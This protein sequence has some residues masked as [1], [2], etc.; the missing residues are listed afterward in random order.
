MMVVC[1]GAK[2]LLPAIL[3]FPAKALPPGD[4]GFTTVG[5]LNHK[6]EKAVLYMKACVA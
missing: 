5:R 6:Q 2:H 4:S 3:S 1:M